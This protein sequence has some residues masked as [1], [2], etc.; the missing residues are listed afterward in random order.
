[1]FNDNYVKLQL[2]IIPNIISNI[3]KWHYELKMKF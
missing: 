1:M 2:L 3:F